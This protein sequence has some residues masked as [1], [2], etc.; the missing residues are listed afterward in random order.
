MAQ[1]RGGPA[2]LAIV[3]SAIIAHWLLPLSLLLRLWVE[4]STQ[5]GSW[6]ATIFFLG[7]YLVFLHIAGTWS[8][9]GFRFRT[10]LPLVFVA[11]A[12]G[13]W[14]GWHAAAHASPVGDSMPL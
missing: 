11:T 5:M 4:R 6:L 3:A 1:T 12:A 7:A 9:F 8:W 2:A 14:P 13:T 10:I